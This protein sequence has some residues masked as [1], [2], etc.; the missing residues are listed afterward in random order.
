MRSVAAAFLLLLRNLAA[1]VV[2]ESVTEAGLPHAIQ[3]CVPVPSDAPVVGW[4]IG[5][6][7]TMVVT[8][9]SILCVACVVFRQ[10]LLAAMLSV[11]DAIVGGVLR[12]PN[13]VPA[14][15]EL[16][17]ALLEQPRMQK[18]IAAAVNGV[19]RDETTRAEISQVVCS[20]LKEEHSR[21]QISSVVQEVLTD[22]RIEATIGNVVG[23]TLN[24]STV[25]NGILGAIKGTS[26]EVFTEATHIVH[27]NLPSWIWDIS[28]RRN[29]LT[30]P[31]NSLR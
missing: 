13:M 14:I 6:I 20:V 30:G 19:L 17:A 5:A 28:R 15:T 11:I 31:N 24:D 10:E 29:Y 2:T 27:H 12:G 7:L 18:A 23:G 22:D 3:S 8:G 21:A 16:V 25:A 1:E 26:K 4:W 9:I